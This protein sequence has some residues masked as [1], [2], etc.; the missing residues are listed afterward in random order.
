MKLR[1]RVFPVRLKNCVINEKNVLATKFFAERDRGLQHWYLAFSVIV[2]SSGLRALIF[3]SYSRPGGRAL[4]YSSDFPSC[5]ISL[6]PTILCLPS[7]VGFLQSITNLVEITNFIFLSIYSYIFTTHVMHIFKGIKQSRRCLSPDFCAL[8]LS[9]NVLNLC[10]A[11][12]SR[13]K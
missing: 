6:V 2:P 10:N 11:Y 7:R 13:R 4:M 9:I 1:K 8:C 3:L 5:R 12:R